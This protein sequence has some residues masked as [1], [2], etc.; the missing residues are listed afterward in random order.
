M[1]KILDFTGK[2]LGLNS[3]AALNEL[4]T[5]TKAV[6]RERIL[7]DVAYK[8][9][10]KKQGRIFSHVP[11]KLSLNPR[12]WVRDGKV[13]VTDDLVSKYINEFHPTKLK[14]LGVTTAQDVYN[15]IASFPQFRKAMAMIPTTKISAAPALKDAYTSYAIEQAAT[16]LARQK[17]LIGLG[18][19]GVASG[20]GY[21]VYGRKY[22]DKEE[23]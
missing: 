2:V 7:A 14:D 5:L 17:A 10:V 12:N 11:I 22:G 21:D 3:R 6:A 4:K 18:S 8:A 9:A 20:V 15:N 13:S 16:K 19:A 1:G 23:V